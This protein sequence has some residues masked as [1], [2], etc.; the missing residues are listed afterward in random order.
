M[1]LRPIVEYPHPVLKQRCAEVTTFDA[2]L[3]RLLDDMRDTM[4]DAE[5]LGLAANQV[6][7]SKRIFTM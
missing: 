6:A 3:G 5:G 4:A 2:E 7:V 1:A